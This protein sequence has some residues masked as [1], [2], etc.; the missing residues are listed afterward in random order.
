MRND[1]SEDSVTP[2]IPRLRDALRKARIDFAYGEN[3]DRL[4][5]H[6]TRLMRRLWQSAGASDIWVCERVAHT[7]GTCRMGRTGEEAVVDPYGR[8]FETENL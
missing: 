1:V 6:D 2:S 5:A 8:S 3:E 7:L 4:N